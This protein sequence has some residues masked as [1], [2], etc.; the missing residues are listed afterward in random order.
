[1]E[2]QDIVLCQ[3]SVKYKKLNGVFLIMFVSKGIAQEV[4]CFQ[5][6][7]SIWVQAPN[8]P[9]RIPGIISEFR[10][11]NTF[12]T[13]LGIAQNKSKKKKNSSMKL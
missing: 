4:G 3:Y 12:W 11:R 13:M 9:P 6:M 10:G 7:W 1:M 2:T 5:F 8:G